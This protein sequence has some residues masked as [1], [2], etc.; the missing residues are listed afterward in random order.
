MKIEYN[1]QTSNPLYY[2]NIDNKNSCQWFKEFIIKEFLKE[3]KINIRIKKI[4]EE[5]LLKVNKKEIRCISNEKYYWKEYYIRKSIKNICDEIDDKDI[6][7]YI[8]KE[9]K[10]RNEKLRRL[11][12]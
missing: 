1:M 4:G 10:K 12:K 2:F 9:N 5:F 6:I 8:K 7:T 3:K 11:K